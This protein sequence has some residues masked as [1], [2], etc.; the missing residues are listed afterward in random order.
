MNKIQKIQL[1]AFLM[2]LFATILSLFISKKKNVDHVSHTLDEIMKMSPLA[3]CLM[4]VKRALG[5]HC[6][7]GVFVKNVGIMNLSQ[8]MN[9]SIRFVT[10]LIANKMS[11][12]IW[13]QL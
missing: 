12:Q 13:L 10:R 3:S 6:G 9:M 5:W 4:T 11:L 7:L 8:K 2:F 1:N